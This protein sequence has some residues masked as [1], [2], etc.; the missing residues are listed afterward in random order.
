MVREKISYKSV[1]TVAFVLLA[2]V[3]L[4][5]SACF[6]FAADVDATSGKK[7]LKS[8][9]E[10]VRVTQY[11]GNRVVLEFRGTKLS[12]P[13]PVE[14]DGAAIALDWK[15]IRFPRNT[16]KQDWWDEYG[17]YVLRVSKPKS[18]EWWQKFDYSLAQ[19]VQAVS[20]DKN[21]VRIL[22]TGE[23][24]LSIKKISGMDGSDIITVDLYAESE[25]TPPR[26]PAPNVHSKNDPLGM[27]TPVTLE[28]RDVSVRDVLRM[29]AD[30][31]HLNLVLDPSVPDNQLTF[32]F[33]N[34]KF[35][36]VFSYMLRMN[37]LS[38]A[39]MGKTLVVGT[40]E[41]IGKTV[42]HNIIKEYSIA[43][44]DVKT[45]PAI[46]MGVV[47]LS[48]P[49]VADDRRRTLF[50][51][52]TPEQHKQIEALLNRIDNPGKQLMLE[53]RLVEV[54]DT[55]G[56]EFDAMV[57]AVYRG[58]L[59]SYSGSNG[60]AGEYTYSNKATANID[61]TISSTTPTQGELPIAGKLIDNAYNPINLADNTL[62]LLDSGL[63]ALETKNKG[64][65]L[66]NPSVVAA[67]GQKATIKLTHN[68][69][70]QSGTD[71]NGNATFSNQETGPTIE[72]TPTIGR[73]GFVT[74]KLKIETGDIVSWR[75][76]SAN[77]NTESPET[78]KR[79]VETQIRVRDGELF[80][81]GGLNQENKSKNISRVPLLGYIPLIGEFFTSRTNTHIKSQMA[82]IVV[83]HIL[84]VPSGAIE[85]EMLPKSS[86]I[87]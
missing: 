24:P 11:G 51:T 62:K 53:A 44:G 18:N 43:Y 3:F 71:D 38:Y 35:S 57:S 58:W 41:S 32:S 68:Y 9:I 76:S 47:Q 36:E 10:A 7:E 16:D 13:A 42:G 69:L 8:V 74:L 29:L 55:A 34:A 59:F 66:A 19:R 22:V 82:F 81:I 17:W 87:Q 50:I 54:S 45:L 46:I 12:Q 61:S 14:V 33:K 2:A 52:A 65:V 80:M 78:T 60:M 30:M 85:K 40:N 23:K 86:L 83:P 77:S 31:R 26:Q 37:D 6:A 64:R 27:D 73:D 70:Y 20:N 75:K 15:D 56:Q 4:L 49:P 5:T 67:D 84:D 21:G 72:M 79:T 1:R 25:V 63:R 48:K 28:L 39:L